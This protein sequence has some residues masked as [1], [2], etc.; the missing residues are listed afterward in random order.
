MS[1]SG[2]FEGGHMTAVHPWRVDK[3]HRRIRELPW[4][5]SNRLKTIERELLAHGRY[6]R[7]LEAHLLEAQEEIL[8]LRKIV[9]LSSE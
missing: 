1:D 9:D 5:P 7:V 2:K 3:M 6:T 8:S 4:W